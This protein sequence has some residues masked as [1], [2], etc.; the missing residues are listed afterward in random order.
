[1]IELGVLL[2][3]LPA[4]ST[5][6][7]RA[8]TF[9]RFW[10]KTLWGGK[11][12]EIGAELRCESTKGL[13]ALAVAFWAVE[14]EFLEFL[15]FLELGESA[16][17]RDEVAAEVCAVRGVNRPAKERFAVF[18]EA[19]GRVLVFKDRAVRRTQA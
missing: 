19:N 18:R 5:G 17:L 9:W 11:T 12:P 15:E 4:H 13:D 2:F 6:H 10:R 8:G 14:R 3:D 16:E 7:R 1:L